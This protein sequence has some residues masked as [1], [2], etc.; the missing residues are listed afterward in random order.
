MVVVVDG[1]GRLHSVLGSFPGKYVC[2]G[3]E[4]E[5]AMCLGSFQPLALLSCCVCAL[6]SGC[7]YRWALR[8]AQVLHTSLLRG[9]VC[10]EENCLRCMAQHL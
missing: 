10:C 6:G 2:D 5:G 3:L 9:R 1:D 4:V 7:C 8:R